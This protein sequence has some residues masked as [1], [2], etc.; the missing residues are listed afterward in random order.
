MSRNNRIVST[1]RTKKVKKTKD[2]SRL[3]RVRCKKLLKALQERSTRF[4]N[5]CEKF[6]DASNNFVTYCNRHIGTADMN[7]SVLKIFVSYIIIYVYYWKEYFYLNYGICSFQYQLEQ[8]LDKIITVRDTTLHEVASY[9]DLF[10]REGGQNKLTDTS[11][12]GI[13]NFYA[14]NDLTDDDL[15]TI[16]EGTLKLQLQQAEQAITE[17]VKKVA[18]NLNKMKVT[19]KHQ[20]LVPI[21]SS[22][23]IN[24]EYRYEVNNTERT[25]VL[26]KG[27]KQIS[28]FSDN[29]ESLRAFNDSVTMSRDQSTRGKVAVPPACK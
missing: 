26:R 24:F 19:K 23:T 17:S 18:D 8:S 5:E 27:G 11:L 12:E 10:I 22:S 6:S 14:S 21:I 28:S 20:N 2:E 25:I 7:K 9:I 15:L 16:L 1:D 3:A 13:Y 4:V 29:L